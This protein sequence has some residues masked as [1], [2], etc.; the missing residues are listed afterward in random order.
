[1]GF[2]RLVYESPRFVEA[3]AFPA[4][5]TGSMPFFL[6]IAAAVGER[7]KPTNALPA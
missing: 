7:R 6:T 5:Y 4:G 2:L 3:Y 1:M